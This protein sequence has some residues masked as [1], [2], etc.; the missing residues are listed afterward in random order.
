MKIALAQLNPTVGALLS[1]TQKMLEAITRAKKE[2]IDLLVFP[3][4]AICGYPPQDLL[5][6]PDFIDGITKS[7]QQLI[8]A[9]S[10]IALIVGCVRKNV[11]GGEKNLFN[12]AALIQDKELVGFQDKMLLPDYDVFS[13]RRYFQ[14]GDHSELWSVGGK[15]IAITLCEDIWQHSHNLEY[16][17]YPI[18]PV[19]LL[20]DKKPDL[21]V[22]LSASP[23]EFN[24][25][26]I[27]EQ[28]CSAVA[29]TLNCPVL[30]CNQVGG[31]DGLIFD[32]HS[33]YMSSDGKKI[34]SARG[35]EEDFLII[36]KK[37][38]KPCKSDS[39]QELY[40][41]LV[42][43]VRDYFGKLG[44]KK[45][46]LGLSGGIDSAVVAV[47]AKEA[48]GAENV[49]ALA[50]PSRYSSS[51]SFKD[52]QKLVDHLGILFETLSIESVF[53][54]S[55]ETLSPFFEGQAADVTEENLQA[56]IRGVLLMAFCNKFHYLLLGTSNKSEIAMGYTT[57]YG[58]M[59]GA[60]SVLSDVTKGLVYALADW[61][62][63]REEVIPQSILKK[64]P[65]AE[66]AFDQ[67]DS[68][69]LPAYPVVDAVL[70]GYVEEHLS[71]IEIAKK[72]TIPL[73]LVKELVR[74][75]HLNEYKRRQAPPGLR[76]SKRAFT[77]GRHFPIVQCWNMET[78]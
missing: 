26:S 15:S 12:S 35:F 56:R 16:S 44:M 8:A 29:L 49:L 5:L 65:T 3:E 13:E 42:L 69:A 28:V 60:L 7:L 73:S 33:L 75:I 40:S 52:A 54:S 14:P 70:K 37:S 64:V 53:K 78:K 18:D 1:N 39:I 71:P 45:A 62:N 32:G 36:E 20:K 61:I 9:S 51:Q 6:L 41:A 24:R 21:V 23:Y 48:L 46:C 27:R 59:C 66:L 72:N 58:D 77:T 76:V 17:N 11:F 4:L 57:L 67:K 47:I 30:L 31:N 10:G 55:L 43:G 68:D 50:L 74:K 34:V 63:H 22:N 38:K 19:E 25:P 2:G